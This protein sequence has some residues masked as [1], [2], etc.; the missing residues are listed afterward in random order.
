MFGRL[1]VSQFVD[2]S[3]STRT[4]QL[5]GLSWKHVNRHRPV[6]AGASVDD[7]F[8]AEQ[9]VPGVQPPGRIPF[10]SKEGMLVNGRLTAFFAMRLQVRLR[11][12]S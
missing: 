5:A 8:L 3:R 10:L 4:H 6:P 11:F 12:L 7:Y 2:Q 9:S 1:A